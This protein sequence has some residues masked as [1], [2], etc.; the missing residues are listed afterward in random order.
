LSPRPK[1]ISLG[2]KRR[3]TEPLGLTYA[4]ERDDGQADG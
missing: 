4:E 2:G 1:A 3:A